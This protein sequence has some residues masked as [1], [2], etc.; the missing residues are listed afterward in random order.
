ML[1]R[2]PKTCQTGHRKSGH[3]KECSKVLIKK[4]S[5]Q[6]IAAEAKRVATKVAEDAGEVKRADGD[7]TT[8]TKA[9][10]VAV[11]TKRV[12]AVKD[13]SSASTPTKCSVAKAGNYAAEAK[14]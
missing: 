10:E 14:Q 12:A 8:V 4:G 6:I 3:G 9:A 5:L 13:D 11:E 1:R 7:L 2:V